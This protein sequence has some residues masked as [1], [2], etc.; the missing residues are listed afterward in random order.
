[1]YNFYNLNPNLHTSSSHNSVTVEVNTPLTNE[2]FYQLFKQYY[3]H[4]SEENEN[5][6]GA[7]LNEINY[8]IGIIPNDNTQDSTQIHELTIRSMDDL[9]LLICTTEE[10][11]VFLPVF[12]DT[13]ELK[14]WNTE[15]IIT[16]SV[17]ARWLWQFVLRQK[18]F[19]GVVFNPGSIGWD[20]SLEHIAS[21]LEDLNQ[22]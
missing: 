10:R 7:H 12:T 2:T 9:N 5:L 20:I 14:H 6:L 11:E 13:R 22:V 8:I 19:S 21:L 18:N 15:P 3:N 4:A 16:L 1:M 17:P